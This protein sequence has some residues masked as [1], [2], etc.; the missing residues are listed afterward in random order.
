MGGCWYFYRFDYARYTE[1]RPTL[2]AATS[3]TTFATLAVGAETQAIV[4]ALMEGEMS[5]LSAR[6][7]F[8]QA[9]CCLGEPLLFDRGLPRFVAVLARRR[10]AEDAAELL[11]EMLAG[12]KNLEPWLM[13]P[14]GLLGFLK[15]EE[16]LELQRSYATLSRKGRL[17]VAKGAQPRR[18]RRGGLIGRL[19]GFGRRL[20]NSDPEADEMLLP[21]AELIAEAVT[22]GEGIAVVAA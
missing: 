20:F 7:A 22:N 19:L 2:R 21:L 11:G 17:G 8:V 18:R 4:D 13:P 9:V 16:T 1:M 6:Q 15:P 12:G 3:P 14:A 5:L 10:G